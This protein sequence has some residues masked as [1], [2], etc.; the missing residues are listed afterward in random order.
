MGSKSE[1]RSRAELDFSNFCARAADNIKN[2]QEQNA[3]A[4][5]RLLRALCSQKFCR[6]RLRPFALAHRDALYFCSSD[7]TCCFIWS[8][9]NGFRM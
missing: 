9:V 8:G 1:I 3:L 4:A 6:L 5:S 2:R 7:S